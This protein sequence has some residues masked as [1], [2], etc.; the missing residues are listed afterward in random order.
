MDTGK[1]APESPETLRIQQSQ[2]VRGLRNVQMF[3]V[4][5]IELELPFGFCRYD[6]ARG[7]FHYNPEK[8][9]AFKI[10]TLSSLGY[11][12]LFLNLGPY[13]KADIEKRCA[14]GEGLK[15]I[16]EYTDDGVE[17]R[18]AAGVDSTLEVQYRYFEQ[19]K[20]PE[21]II[22]VGFPPNRVSLHLAKLK[23]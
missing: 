8:I 23:G 20:E 5:T 1:C 10:M 11:E 17:V 21:N 9:D 22:V 6:N 13:N 3:P 14:A 4:G 2:L 19:T 16:T 15:F 18:C 12:N 7:V